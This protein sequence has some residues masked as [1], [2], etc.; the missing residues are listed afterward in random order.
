MRAQCIPHPWFFLPHKAR[1]SWGIFFMFFCIYL[2]F[3][4]VGNPFLCCTVDG[5]NRFTIWGFKEVI[6]APVRPINVVW[7]RIC[8]PKVDSPS[9]IS[10][11]GFPW[12]LRLMETPS[13][14]SH[15]PNIFLHTQHLCFVVMCIFVLVWI[16][17]KNWEWKRTRIGLINLMT[18]GTS[19]N[20]KRV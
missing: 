4:M 8:S 6:S 10:F 14:A 2:H 1:A 11:F 12:L 19:Q 7:N 13:W 18:K 20:I 5:K 17:S 3:S 16:I 9:T 15:D